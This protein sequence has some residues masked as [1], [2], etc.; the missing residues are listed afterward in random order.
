LAIVER[1]SG[2]AIAVTGYSDERARGRARRPASSAHL[3]TPV[4]A[5]TLLAAIWG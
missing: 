2:Q 5:A 3:V 1:P 4:D